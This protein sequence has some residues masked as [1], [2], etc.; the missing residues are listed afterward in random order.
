[1][2]TRQT[3]PRSLRITPGSRREPPPPAPTDPRMTV[4]RHGARAVQLSGQGCDTPVREQPGC[5]LPDPCQPP[6]RPLI[7]AQPFVLPSRPSHQRTI[8]AHPHR[9]HRCRVRLIGFRHV[10]GREL[11]V[12]RSSSRS[13]PDAVTAAPFPT[14]LKTTVI[15]QRPSWWFGASVRTA[16]P[17]GQ[18]TSITRPAPQSTRPPTPSIIA[19]L[20]AF[21]FTRSPCHRT[22]A[23]VPGPG[24]AGD[25]GRCRTRPRP[26]RRRGPALPLAACPAERRSPAR[27]PPG[28]RRTTPAPPPPPPTAPVPPTAC[29]PAGSTPRPPDADSPP[30]VS[31]PTLL[32]SVPS[33]CQYRPRQGRAGCPRRSVRSCRCR[34]HRYPHWRGRPCGSPSPARAQSSTRADG[35]SPPADAAPR[36]CRSRH[37]GASPTGHA[38]PDDPATAAGTAPANKPAAGLPDHHAR[39][40]SPPAR[41]ASSPP[42]PDTP[43]P[44]RPTPPGHWGGPQDGPG[45][46]PGRPSRRKPEKTTSRAP[47]SDRSASQPVDLPGAPSHHGT[48][49]PITPKPGAASH[50]HAS[51][52]SCLPRH[53]SLQKSHTQRLPPGC[54]QRR[55]EEDESRRARL[56]VTS[57]DHPGTGPTRGLGQ[58]DRA[59]VAQ[60]LRPVLP[61]RVAAPNPPDQRLHPEVGSQEV[62]TARIV[63]T[64][65]GVVDSGH[66]T[67]TRSVRALAVDGCVLIAG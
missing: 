43:G 21:M 29:P 33:S 42:S 10:N 48:N 40:P 18:T 56:A 52:R 57:V 1:M 6:P 47:G 38:H 32:T 59:R 22:A 62:Q 39:R 8:K 23:P 13:T 26:P 44:G 41:P 49:A 67:C 66:E 30:T 16:A 55:D 24:T 2:G 61:D 27:S 45:R 46:G 4:S 17:E 5:P 25:G 15:N 37:R 20:S 60:L 63:Q 35:R 50:A 12:H 3:P 65:Q 36:R 9:G 19:S 58:P 54:Q 7:T 11:I 34:H 31:T 64:S 53:R 51:T 28:R 14:T